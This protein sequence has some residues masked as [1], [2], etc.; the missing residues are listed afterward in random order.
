MLR[1]DAVP[2][3]L[4]TSRSSEAYWRRTPAV[5]VVLS[6]ARIRPSANRPYWCWRDCHFDGSKS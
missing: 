1:S 5:T 2:D 4:S 3:P 6:V